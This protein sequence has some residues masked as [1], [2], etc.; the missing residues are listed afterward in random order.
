M[1]KQ[2]LLIG[3][4]VLTI[5]IVA[6][7]VAA[8][9]G[10]SGS[11]FSFGEGDAAVIQL[12]GTISPTASDGLGAT[13]GITP[14]SV[15]SL[16]QRATDQGADAIIYEINSGGGAVV[17]SKEVMREIE[18]VK[19]PT[20]CRFRDISASGAYLFALGCDRIVADSTTLTGSIGVQGSYFEFTELMGELGVEYINITS[21]EHKDLGTPFRNITDEE[22]EM[23]Q[24]KADRVHEEFIKQVQDERN[25]T[26]D[27][28]EQARTGEPFL[29][30][31]AKELGL[32]DKLGGRQTSVETAENL[33]DQELE[34]FRIER[35]T[36]FDFLSLL[37]ADVS[38]GNFLERG[39]PLR[40]E[41]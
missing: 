21:G 40:A 34:T 18:S 27:Q 26:E 36:G 2:L 12:S 20:V 31:R 11:S 23:L 4:A 1:D 32:V 37:T 30:E 10:Q 38:F 29:G 22:R 6:V 5:I 7:G 28:L 39:S 33:T 15:R 9:S 14:E 35:R 16:N 25:L 8:V 24:K 3:S 13:G 41:Y 17:A 19:V